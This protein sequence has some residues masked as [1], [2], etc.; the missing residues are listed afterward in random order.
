MADRHLLYKQC[1][2]E[3]ADELGK[4][5]TFMAKPDADAAG[6]SCHVHVSLW[7]DGVNAF[8]GEDDFGG[9]ACSQL[10]RWFLGGWIQKAPELM[11]FMAPTVNSYKRY[12]IGSWAPTR[13]AWARDNRTA[14]FR[15]VGTNDSLRIECRIP[16]ADCNPYLTYAAALAAGLHGIEHRIEPPDEFA[17]NAYD[18]ADAAHVAPTL[19]DATDDFANSDF[20]KEAF[21][22]TVVGHYS[23]FFR[24]EQQA[25]DV[26]VT[27]WEHR[28]YFERI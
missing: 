19:R 15:I 4:S 22:E 25:F 12:Q 2:K 13:L 9:V 24:T 20:A 16:G 11:V 1:A 5:V 14:G 3:T 17:G 28:R 10:F 6:S 23:H 7:K 26:A 18:A 27:D 8:Q 21:G